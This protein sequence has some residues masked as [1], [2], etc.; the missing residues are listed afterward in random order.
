MLGV[1]YK[2]RGLESAQPKTIQ[3]T[4]CHFKGGWFLDSLS[5]T[6]TLLCNRCHKI[7]LS[8]KGFEQFLNTVN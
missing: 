7:T 2:A 8:L 4:G 1:K 5:H 3:P 6:I